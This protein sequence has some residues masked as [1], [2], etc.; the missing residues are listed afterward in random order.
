MSDVTQQMARP[1]ATQRMTQA[2][3]PC[4]P[5]GLGQAATA[6]QVMM[7]AW[8]SL[9]PDEEYAGA[10]VCAVLQVLGCVA[11]VARQLG[12]ESGGQATAPAASTLPA[13]GNSSCST[14]T[15]A[16]HSGT[17]TSGGSSRASDVAV[18]SMAATAAFDA[19]AVLVGVK[20]GEAGVVC[21]SDARICQGVKERPS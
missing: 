15:A 18:A 7:W 3:P 19:A 17:S 21:C 2:L 4:M 8:R 13:S 14:S 10:M 11:Q 1:G 16:Q 9:G 6:L 12:S 20:K 5:S